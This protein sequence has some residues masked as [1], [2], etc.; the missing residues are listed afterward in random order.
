METS[1]E[2]QAKQMGLVNCSK[3]YVAPSKL[4]GCGVFA[5]NNYKKGELLETGLMMV[6]NNVDG[7]EN[8]HL[9]TWSDDR[10]TWA[11]GSG[12]IPFYNHSDEPNI[13]KKGNLADNTMMIVA[14]KDI[15]QHDELLN[16]YMSATWRKCFIGELI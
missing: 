13:K 14:L 4:G 2:E 15:K 12:S 5:K 3:V 10:K 16:T 11:A 6:L 7:N 9:F 8:P 1:L